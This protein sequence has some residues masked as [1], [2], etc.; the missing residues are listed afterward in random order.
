MQTFFLF[1]CIGVVVVT[2]NA[3]T[4]VCCYVFMEFLVLVSMV[5]KS[6]LLNLLALLW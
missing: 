2:R 6:D 5:L 3:M 4:S 1:L